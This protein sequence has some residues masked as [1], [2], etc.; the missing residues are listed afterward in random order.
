MFG[1]RSK[2]LFVTHLKSR[3]AVGESS[4]IT[5]PVMFF[6]CIWTY[7]CQLNLVTD[8]CDQASDKRY[9]KFYTVFNLEITSRLFLTKAAQHKCGTGLIIS[10]LLG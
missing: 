8:H 6:K 4:V 7:G 10:M 9:T 5:S 2:A 3:F 1:I